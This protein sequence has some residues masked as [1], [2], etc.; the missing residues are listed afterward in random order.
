M[1]RAV[2]VFFGLY[3][4]AFSSFSFG[5]Q[6]VFRLACMSSCFVNVFDTWAAFLRLLMKIF[7]PQNVLYVLHD[8]TLRFDTS[9]L[10]LVNAYGPR[11]LFL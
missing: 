8:V 1:I 3:F 11:S 6:F 7:R 10:S 4:L 2:V 5:R 9:E